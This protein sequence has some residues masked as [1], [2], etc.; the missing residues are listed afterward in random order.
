LKTMR[1]CND[2][3]N[4]VLLKYICTLIYKEYSLIIFIL[5]I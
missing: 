4:Y 3:M 2:K 5:Y 1:K